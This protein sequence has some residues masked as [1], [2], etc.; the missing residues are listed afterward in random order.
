[1]IGQPD[2]YEGLRISPDGRAVGVSRVQTA[3]HDAGVAFVEFNRG[4]TTHLGLGFWGAWS[5]DGERIAWSAGAGAP[6]VFAGPINRPTEREQ[7]THSPSSESVV[8]WSSDGQF[9]LYAAQHN[10]ATAAT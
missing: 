5:P 8:D 10:D 9:I 7:L 4:I 2:A 6:K 3:S 1:M